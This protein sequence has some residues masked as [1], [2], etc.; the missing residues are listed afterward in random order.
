MI[1][2][3]EWKTTVANNPEKLFT[4]KDTRTYIPINAKM[5]MIEVASRGVNSKDGDKIIHS[6]PLCIDYD[7]TGFATVN[8]INKALYLMQVY[9][10]IYFNV[11]FDGSDFTSKDYDEIMS[12]GY[13]GKINRLADKGSTSRIKHQAI[14]LQND[15]KV[16]EKML[17]KELSDEVARNN[18]PYKRMKPFAGD[19]IDTILERIN[20]D[21]SPEKI[22]QATQEL[23]ELTKE[24]KKRQNELHLIKDKE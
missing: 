19:L 12:K 8:T 13:Q 2:L 24:A 23:E 11:D 6:E 15:F 21:L 5:R 14:E 16:F 20:M 1:T 4:D 17:N 3:Q 7:E 9:L 22:Q 18:D 10:T